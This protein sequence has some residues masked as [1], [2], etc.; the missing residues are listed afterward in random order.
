ME[1][2]VTKCGDCVFRNSIRH[3]D[4]C[5]LLDKESCITYKQ[6]KT[7]LLNCPLKQGEIT[8]KLQ[9]NV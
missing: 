9:N 1:I 2:K 4:T 5:K 6:L 3:I 7:V 8:V